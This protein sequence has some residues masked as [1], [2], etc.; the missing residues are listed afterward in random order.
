MPA[1]QFPFNR[2][3]CLLKGSLLLW[4][5]CDIIG[6]FSQGF[7]GADVRKC[8]LREGTAIGCHASRW[9]SAF[10]GADCL[11]ARIKDAFEAT[12]K[13]GDIPVLHSWT[14]YEASLPVR[15]GDDGASKLYSRPY[16][17]REH[18]LDVAVNR[19]ERTGQRRDRVAY[20]SAP[21][22]RG[23]SAAIL[24]M[25]CRSVERGSENSF[26]HYLYMPFA[27][28]DGNCNSPYT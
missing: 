9:W 28:N 27:N 7:A 17:C 19:L 22:M 15:E 14:S 23:K 21:T 26:T 12:M 6:L 11:A 5:A 25:F 3:S 16:F 10:R 24:P 1:R 18:D 8:R 4:I 13:A 2:R 20:L